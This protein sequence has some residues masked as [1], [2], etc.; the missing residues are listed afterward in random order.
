MQSVI[1]WLMEG[2]GVIR[3]QVLRDLLG[4]EEGVWAE[5]RQRTA[6]VGW[7]RQFIDAL[8][9]DGGWAERRWTGTVWTLGIVIDCRLPP[10][11]PAL[12]R[13][14]R[15]FI[16]A[17]LSTERSTDEKWLLTRVDLCHLG[18]WLK[19]GSY[20]LGPDERFD[21]LAALLLRMQMG[22][23]G[24]N[25]RRRTEPKTSHSSFHTTFN[26]L[27]ALLVAAD[28]GIVSPAAFRESE[29]RAMEFA[30]RHHLYRSDRTGLV[31]D[32]R[33]EHLSFPSYWHYNV[34]R[35]LDYMRRCPEI[36]DRRANDALA[37]IEARRRSNGRWP[38]EKRIP[39][40]TLFDMEKFG[41]D[42][43]WNTLRALRIL[44][45]ASRTG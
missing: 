34:L 15:K 22:D 39:G 31:I 6:E 17:N 29:T 27:E 37:L 5:E 32:G 7:G 3:W 10:E 36:T 25:C 11:N 4:A 13:A 42:S 41:G 44:R 19:I 40:S 16:D 38:L 30:L 26:I 45:S 20:F 12:L 1:D 8:G 21:H 14:A 2:D 24:W 18:F 23:G 28:S 9:P 35:G 43:R 33:F